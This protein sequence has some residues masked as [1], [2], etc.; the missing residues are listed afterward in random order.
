M[1]NE[2]HKC[3]VCVQDEY[4]YHLQILNIYDLEALY[5]LEH[6]TNLANFISQLFKYF[7]NYSSL[8]S[9]LQ[10]NASYQESHVS[11]ATLNRKQRNSMYSFVFY[12]KA[13]KYQGNMLM[14]RLFFNGNS[15]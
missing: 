3:N 15:S 4:E 6:K 5:T 8:C 12:V 1:Q 11:S 2:Y 14:I 7:R 13:F 10:K 9:T